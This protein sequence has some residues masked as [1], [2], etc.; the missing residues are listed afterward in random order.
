MIVHRAEWVLPIS[1]PPI[2]DGWVAVEGGRIAGVGSGE[3]PAPA[4]PKEP[5]EPKEPEEPKEP[6]VILPSLV[7][8][9]THLELSWMRGAVAPAS[10]MPA[11]AAA[12]MDRRRSQNAEPPEPIVE[13]IRAAREA[14]T[15]A[16]GDVT[17][18]LASFEPLAGSGVRAAVFFE[19]LGF[20]TATPQADAAAA[21][22]RVDRLRRVPRVRVSIVP[23][24]PYSVSA[25]LMRAI[26][27]LPG[28]GPISIHLA[29]SA[30]EL[31]FLAQGTG[32][33]RPVLAAVGS[34]VDLLTH[35]ACRPLEYI[36][37]AGLLSPR[38]MAVHGVHL[39]E[40]EL[41]TLAAAGATVVTCP[42]SNLWTGAGPPPVERF[43]A[44]GVR[45]AIG[46]DS[47]ASVD[48]L[49]IFSE[50]AAVRAAAPGVP[51]AR[52]LESA[53][54]TGAEALGFGGEIGT[55]E[56]GKHA[57]LISVRVPAGV[58]DVEEYLVSGVPAADV[59][60]LT[61]P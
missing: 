52:L 5:K 44:S 48:D 34:W 59:Q 36:A 4:E 16:I 60:W 7:N 13:A 17:N 40:V 26:A 15:G 14:G 42:R 22:A 56:P 3:P 47:L 29:E 8:A 45:V 10:S 32:A 54:R 50:L 49:S 11:W 53:T 28:G 2:R 39:A 41:A 35:P 27:E 25:A 43:Y 37:R 1:A 46:T 23:H 58:V 19:Q 9:H 30:E 24:A 38:L 12:L 57:S 31:E 33:W 61:A 21:Q 20:R 18:T 55:I 6:H 51:A